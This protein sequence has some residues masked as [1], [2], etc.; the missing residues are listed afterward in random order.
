MQ[1][2]RTEGG[3]FSKCGSRHSAAYIRFTRSQELHAL[4]ADPFSKRGPRLSAAHM[5]FTDSHDQST[6]VGVLDGLRIMREQQL[7]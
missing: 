4:R 1:T 6:R 7:C 5:R 3:K 2:K